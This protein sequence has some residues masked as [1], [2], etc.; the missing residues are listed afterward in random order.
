MNNLSNKQGF[1]NR[2]HSKIN[3]RNPRYKYDEIAKSCNVSKQS[4]SL[5]VRTGVIRDK[6]LEKLA[7]F[8]NT[9]TIWLKYGYM[10]HPFPKD[11]NNQSNQF[12]ITKEMFSLVLQRIS[13]LEQQILEQAR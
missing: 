13:S 7:S 8:F 9:T 1:M 12:E 10:E 6:H 2:L 5:W 4:V 3:S 11:G